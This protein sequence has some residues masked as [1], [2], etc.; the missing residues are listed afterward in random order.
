MSSTN[1]TPAAV[2]Y[3]PALNETEPSQAID[4]VAQRLAR[5]LDHHSEP[6]GTAYHVRTAAPEDYGAQ[7]RT[8]VRE[9]LRVDPGKNPETDGV[10]THR[11]YLLN[12]LPLLDDETPSTNILVRTV[13]LLWQCVKM[14]ARFVAAC[15]V[16]ESFSK[17]QKLSVFVGGVALA[18]VL[19]YT[20]LAVG[21]LARIVY[22][23]WKSPPAT[24]NAGP[25]APASGVVAAAPALAPATGATAPLPKASIETVRM[26]P[27]TGFA[28]TWDWVQ[29]A[30]GRF[31]DW[32][33]DWAERVWTWLGS[34]KA[35]TIA[36]LGALGLSVSGLR[37]LLDRNVT[38]TMRFCRYLDEGTARASCTGKFNAL[39]EHVLESS[40][41]RVDVVAYSLGSL[42]ALDSLYP[43]QG[44]PNTRVGNVSTLTT[45]GCPFDFVRTFW[46]EYFDGRT[47]S[48]PNLKWLNVYS[49]VDLLGS[50]FA[51]DDGLKEKATRGINGSSRSVVDT[52]TSGASAMPN[53]NLFY[54]PMGRREML[55]WHAIVFEG[56]IAHSRY[57]VAG[58][59]DAESCFECFVPQLYPTS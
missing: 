5:T 27:T 42:V 15:V 54:D 10:V 28:R 45:I 47:A 31:W 51:N 4:G 41:S 11:V 34:A 35:K 33:C 16:A 30:P 46:D 52:A 29:S 13:N 25:A 26:R 57:W 3:C 20:A 50:N 49:P 58:Q 37:T 7:G 6:I 23:A 43:P 55:L 48:A 1:A 19:L 8:E 14:T 18:G 21:T 17:K 24:A 32:L 9:L 56:F 39:L 40:P 36:V 2:I 38:L 59:L 12:Y 53:A 44:C 22:D